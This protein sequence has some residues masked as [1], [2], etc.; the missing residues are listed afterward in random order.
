V[1]PEETITAKRIVSLG[2]KVKTSISVEDTL[3]NLATPSI[4]H[5][6]SLIIHNSK[7]RHPFTQPQIDQRLCAAP[8]CLSNAP[9]FFGYIVFV[10]FYPY[11]W[12]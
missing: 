5:N 10:P 7:T 9:L 2:R 11:L 4:L 8:S 6:S 3:C 12:H 1:T